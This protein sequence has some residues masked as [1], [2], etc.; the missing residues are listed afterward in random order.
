MKTYWGS[1]GIAPHILTL[2]ILVGKPEEKR[3]CGKPRHRWE[4]IRMDLRLIG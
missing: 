3:P 1:G 4:K 2:N